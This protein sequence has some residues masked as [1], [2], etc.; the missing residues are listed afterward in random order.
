MIDWL[1]NWFQNQCDSEWEHNH[2]IRIETIDNPGWNI[3]IDLLNTHLAKSTIKWELFESSETNWLGYKIE[4]GCF[5]AS[6]DSQKLDFLISIFKEFVE[7]GKVNND[8]ILSKM[9]S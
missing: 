6:G 2:S 4:N 5:F 3:E 7:K 8:Y 1:Q 9:K